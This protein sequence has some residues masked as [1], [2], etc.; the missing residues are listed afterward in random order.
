[1]KNLANKLRTESDFKR[2]EYQGIKV[3]SLRKSIK[4]K[5]N[6]KIIRK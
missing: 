1:M 4:D 6:G 5:Q 3:D 2:L